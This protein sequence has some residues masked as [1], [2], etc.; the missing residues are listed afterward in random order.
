MNYRISIVSDEG[1]DPKLPG[2]GICKAFT[3][4]YVD[5]Q[6][7]VYSVV[8]ADSQV[9]VSN[10]SLLGCSAASAALRAVE[11]ATNSQSK[12]SVAESSESCSERSVN[13]SAVK[14]NVPSSI[15]TMQK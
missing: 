11:I 6:G 5:A 7:K 8:S 4:S 2:D 3:L 14:T 15:V 10:M 1:D 9:E 13:D 12:S